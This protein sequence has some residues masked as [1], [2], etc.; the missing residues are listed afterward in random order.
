MTPELVINIVQ[1]ALY[2]LIL[3]SAPV[4]LVSLVVGLF[5]SILQAATQ[6]NEMTL[7][8]I[9]KLLALFLTLVLAG[10]WILNTLIE[11]TVRLY[12]SIPSVIG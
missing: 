3:V 6:I 2:V 4:L 7:T 12:R 5:V 9:P 8:F 10:P 11:Y 1:N